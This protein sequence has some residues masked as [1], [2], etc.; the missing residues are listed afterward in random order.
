MTKFLKRIFSLIFISFLMLQYMIFISDNN[1]KT[2]TVFSEAVNYSQ[3]YSEYLVELNGS[4]S[5]KNFNNF[6]AV[7]NK[8]EY[9][10]KEIYPNYNKGWNN[11]VKNYISYYSYDN[12]ENFMNYYKNKLKENNLEEEISNA[13]VYGIKIDK[14]LIYTTEANIEKLKNNYPNIE[15]KKTKN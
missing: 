8:D 7:L 13:D 15:Y 5:T 2:V 9:K 10:I 11:T 6:F 1:N 12:L 4:L 3:N 14:I